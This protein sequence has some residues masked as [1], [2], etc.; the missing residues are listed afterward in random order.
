MPSAIVDPG[1][2]A[3]SVHIAGPE[4]ARKRRTRRALDADEARHTVDQARIPESREARV[5]AEQQRA[6]AERRD[7]DVGRPAAELL[8]DLVGEGRGPGE[9]R[10]L[11]QVRA[12]RDVGGGTIQRVPG[13]F[14]GR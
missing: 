2:T 13:C 12:I 14:A 8:E 7:H 5:D 1:A 11:P 10:R 9:E 6:A 4:G 3:V